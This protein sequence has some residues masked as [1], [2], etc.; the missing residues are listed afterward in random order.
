MKKSI[1]EIYALAVCFATIVCF[2]IALGISIYDI[3]RIAKPEFTMSSYEYNRHQS[4]DA[5]WKSGD[6]CSDDKKR[7]RPADEELTKQRLASYQQS[8]KSELR[9]AF[10]SLTQTVIILS[11][12]VIVFLV[13]WRVARRAREANISTQ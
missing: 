6:S 11:I 3:V 13:H 5:Y 2:V 8:I 12:A 9:D 10:Q 4:N 7:Q 1:L